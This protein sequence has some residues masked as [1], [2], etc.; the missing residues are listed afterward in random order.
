MSLSDN[1][2]QYFAE[3]KYNCC[4]AVVCAYCDK[5]GGDSESV[6]RLAEGFGGGMG[7]LKETCGAVTGMFMAIGLHNSAGDQYDPRKTK[8]KTYKD[9]QNSA[10]AFKTIC[11]ALD[12]RDLKTPT[13][14]RPIVSC[15]RCVETAAEILEQYIQNY[16]AGEV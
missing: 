8:A 15:E 13:D 4:Q 1:A 11:G 3:G 6:F 16:S 7:G 12:C 5:Y 14:G 2:K 9:V 10:A